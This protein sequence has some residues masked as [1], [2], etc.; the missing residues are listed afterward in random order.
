MEAWLTS[1]ALKST[2]KRLSREVDQENIAAL[3]FDTANCSLAYCIKK[4]DKVIN[5]NLNPGIPRVP[6]ALLLK[7]EEGRCKIT[8]FGYRAQ[9]LMMDLKPDHIDYHYFEFSK[10]I[11]ICGQVCMFACVCN[12]AGANHCVYG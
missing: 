2:E 12:W 11:G 7:K 8:S 6:T 4:Q 3:D 9:E 5:L 1:R 10:G